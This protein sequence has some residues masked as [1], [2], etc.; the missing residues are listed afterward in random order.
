MPEESA[1]IKVFKDIPHSFWIELHLLD[2]HLLLLPVE[3]HIFEIQQ[4]DS[5]ARLQVLVPLLRQVPVPAGVC[6]TAYD[7]TENAGEVVIAIEQAL[8][9][10]R[11]AQRQIGHN[12]MALQRQ[13]AGM[14][15]P[16]KGYRVPEMVG[17]FDIPIGPDF[18]PDLD[19]DADIS[20]TYGIMA[21]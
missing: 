1:P 10:Q 17:Q 3:A 5:G 18:D 20:L 14:C 12:H 19:V 8:A 11:K 2:G 16:R 7:V 6:M 4:L 21:R 13:Q 15:V 9:R